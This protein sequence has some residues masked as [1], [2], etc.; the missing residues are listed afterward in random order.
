M[1]VITGNSLDNNLV[2]TVDADVL[3]GLE[4][5]DTLTSG[6]D[7]TLN[8]GLGNDLLNGEGTNTTYEFDAGFG[9]DKIVTGSSGIHTIKFNFDIPASYKV[10]RRGMNLNIQMG[11]N[12]L[13]IDNYFQNNNVS[14]FEFNNAVLSPTDM[15][16]LLPNGTDADDWI[17][18]DGTRYTN[19][20]MTVNGGGGEDIIDFFSSGNLT[21]VTIDGGQGDDV[22]R[23]VIANTTIKFG[24][25]SGHDALKIFD[26]DGVWAP[27]VTHSPVNVT[28]DMA[29]NVILSDL[30]IGREGISFY[31][32][33]KNSDARLSLS[34]N[35][36]KL[37]NGQ[38]TWQV[39]VGGQSV[40]L[41]SIYQNS[42]VDA[43]FVASGTTLDGNLAQMGGLV[44]L[45]NG[46]NFVSGSD[47]EQIIRSGQN[48]ISFQ[49][50]FGA[51]TLTM[52]FADNIYGLY[53]QGNPQTHT[54]L[55][56][57]NA[58]ST[59]E[60]SRQGSSLLV[61]DNSTGSQLDIQGY[62]VMAWSRNNITYRFANQNYSYADI[63]AQ[64]TLA[65]TSATVY[66]KAGDTRGYE[67]NNE[68]AVQSY[69]AEDIRF[70]TL[71]D[72]I[73]VNGGTGE[74]QFYL[75]GYS[76][77]VHDSALGGH[78]HVNYALLANLNA[79]GYGV[80]LELHT[81]NLSQVHFSLGDSNSLIV[82]D[83]STGSRLDGYLPAL[84]T[85]VTVY[86]N[87]VLVNGFNLSQAILEDNPNYVAAKLGMTGSTA[88]N[89]LLGVGAAFGEWLT[90]SG[91]GG[92]DTFVGGLGNDVMLVKSL[93]AGEHILVK[94]TNHN[95]SALIGLDSVD[96]EQTNLLW[97]D[98]QTSNAL[99][100]Q[101]NDLLLQS[102]LGGDLRIEEFFTHA[103]YADAVHLSFTH[104]IINDASKTLQ[105]TAG[106]WSGA[107][108]NETRVVDY[109]KFADRVVHYSE[110][111]ALFP[112][113]V[114]SSVP[115]EGDDIIYGDQS[116]ADFNDVIDALG[117]N[118]I[119]YGLT[120]DDTLLGGSGNDSLYGASGND[121]LDGGTGIDSLVGSVGDDS[122][123]VD[124]SADVITE[125]AGE[126]HDA[127]TST[128]TYTLSANVE[129]L[130]LEGT[131]NINGTGN[132]LNNLIIGNTGNNL[133]DGGAGADA[134]LGGLGNDT[135]VVDNVLD[136]VTENV[137]QGTDTVLSSVNYTLGNNLEHLSLQGT[138]N[139]TG[140]GNSLNN[141]ITGNVGNN[142][143]NGGAGNDTLIGGAGNDTYYVNGGDTVTEL[144]SE[145]TD[146]VF[147][148]VTYTL[149]NNIENLTLQGTSNINGT[150]NAL[151]NVLTGNTGNNVLNGGAGNDTLIG[152]A[153]NDTYT[154]NGG[155]TVTETSGQGTD[156]VLSTI[157]YT[158]TANVE[159]LTL[160]G[161]AA[162]NGTGNSLANVLTGN[163]GNNNLSS[164]AGNDTLTGGAGVD[165]LNGGTGNDT[166]L[167]NR[168][169]AVDT[170]I[171]SDTT[172]GNKDTLQL[173][174]DVANDQLWFS[175]SGNNLE[176][177][178]I[179][180]SDRMVVQNWFSGSQ[181]RVE[182]VK[183][184]DGKVLSDANVQ[185][186][187][188]AM[189]TM[190]P[191]PMGQTT[192]TASEQATLAPV[193]VANW[194]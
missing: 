156:T 194:S 171:D 18:I 30:Y 174:A 100:R 16:N 120:Q 131:A 132:D 97:S 147:S 149:G 161:G 102:P 62:T 189:A 94:G 87:G 148:T 84:S 105:L 49:G 119:V 133:L 190:T 107:T 153:G 155:D 70:G 145:G 99:S 29:S 68:A 90:L 43:A 134:M 173:G 58:I 179:G 32:G 89:L 73:Y 115:T 167:F 56:F 40:S 82:E 10:A 57:Q 92:S 114:I 144:A 118:D 184:G 4:G 113:V 124:D 51:D 106:G 175:Q 180:T 25:D 85:P 39:Q 17:Q 162:I 159:N 193:L 101:G 110:I 138:A 52:D 154:V 34:A 33:I 9:V 125:V 11:D 59:Y 123:L 137:N 139:L 28:I 38:N 20:L 14:S 146:L 27:T 86:Q 122:Y 172:V 61:K 168:G 116:P 77:L 63:Q 192:L 37:M 72:R 126:G 103:S 47:N 64:L 140:T 48:T 130:T 177:Q 109:I 104:A 21:S 95:S 44:V 45:D 3:Q 164:G 54:T 112:D 152:G 83:L 41:Q 111:A 96:I 75:T 74:N 36:Y 188:N 15:D 60:F 7:D 35:Q 135:Y 1:A 19:S 80:Q 163:T 169:N 121:I 12:W 186:L 31:L 158:L 65:S 170:I 187:V 79:E 42:N 157:T 91:Q 78:D 128:A 50:S 93:N 142:A 178:I 176:I 141:T 69:Y 53:P 55:A 182:E 23:S 185:N 22:I 150:G 183:A 6:G 136:G 2:G 191:P 98:V 8:G 81:T 129:D 108:T 165:L 5:N 13:T 24:R 117:G 26:Y 160:Q 66:L 143:L 181:Y 67:V 76:V 71:A 127:V 151:N 88:D 46:A 166:Y